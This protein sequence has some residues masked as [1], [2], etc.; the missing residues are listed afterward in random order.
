MDNEATDEMLH[1]LPLA[2][3]YIRDFKGI[4]A[5]RLYQ[6]AVVAQTHSVMGVVGAPGRT[7]EIGPRGFDLPIGSE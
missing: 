6:P 1:T 2:I 3:N 7:R 5:S 4:R